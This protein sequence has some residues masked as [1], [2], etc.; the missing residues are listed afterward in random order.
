[1]TYIKEIFGIARAWPSITIAGTFISYF[2]S[3][4]IE[5]F[6]LLIALMVNDGINYFLKYYIAKPIMGS[7]KWPILGYGTRPKGAKYCSLYVMP[8]SNGEPK[9]SYGMPSGHAQNSVFFSTYLI[10][11]LMSG[12]FN[13]LTKI[14]GTVIFSIIA[15]GIMYSRVYFKCHTFEQVIMGGVIGGLLAALFYK[16]KDRLKKKI[17]R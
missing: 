8:N 14:T 12:N 15:I 6:M 5:F 17:F 10:I 1:M 13:N 9:G 4:N 2:L 3:G 16:N 7:K 11:N